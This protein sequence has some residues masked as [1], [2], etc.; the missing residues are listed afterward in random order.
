MNH[1]TSIFFSILLVELKDNLHTKFTNLSF[2]TLNHHHHHNR[3]FPSSPNSFVVYFLLI[4]SPPAATDTSNPWA[5]FY[6]SIP[7]FSI[8]ETQT[9]CGVWVRLLS[10]SSMLW[11]AIMLLQ[12]RKTVSLPCWAVLPCFRTPARMSL[13]VGLLGSSQVGAIKDKAI[14]NTFE[15]ILQ[16]T[17]VLISLG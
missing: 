9:G 2:E 11:L 17:Y 12:C 15:Q 5:A 6:C 16:G 1:Y 4:Q 10:F 14:T 3:T 7:T 8:R 13:L